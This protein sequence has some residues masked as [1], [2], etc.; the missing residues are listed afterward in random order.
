MLFLRLRLPES[1][2][3]QQCPQ[4]NSLVPSNRCKKSRNFGTINL[5]PLIRRSIPYRLPIMNKVLR[6]LSPLTKCIKTAKLNNT[7]VEFPPDSGRWYIVKCEEHTIRFGLRPLQGAAKHLNGRLHG[8]LD[9]SWALATEMLGYRVIDCTKELA[10]LNNEVVNNAF[11]HGYKPENEVKRK[12]HPEIPENASHRTGATTISRKRSGTSQTSIGCKSTSSPSRKRRKEDWSNPT[13]IITN[14]KT[15]HVYYCFWKDHHC[16]YPVMILAWDN[17][18]P[19]GLEHDLVSTGLLDKNSNPPN[20]YIYKDTD[21]GKNKAIAGWAPGF[22]DGGSKV[23]QRKFPAMFFDP[24]K[25]VSWVSANLLSKFP[26]FEPDPPKKRSHPFNV[27]RR[28]VAKN[29]GFA[30]WEEFEE[31]QKEKGREKRERWVSTP[32][33]SPLSEINDAENGSDTESSA[34][35]YTS[36]VTEKVLQEMRDRAGEITGDSDYAGSD[37][38]STLDDEH[39][40]WE[41]VETDGRPWAW[42]VLRKKSHTDLGKTESSISTPDNNP[43]N[44][45]VEFSVRE[46]TETARRLSIHACTQDEDYSVKEG[47]NAKASDPPRRTVENPAQDGDNQSSRGTPV[48]NLYTANAVN[49]ATPPLTG[50]I[51]RDIT[52]TDDHS[53]PKHSPPPPVAPVFKPKEPLGPAVFELSSYSKGSISWNRENEETSLRLY[54]G[55]GDRVVGTVDAPVNI[56]IDPTTLGGITREEIPESR[57]NVAMTLFGKDPSDASVK[58]VFD[59]PMGSKADIGKVQSRK[60]LRWIRSVVP[61]L[62]LLEG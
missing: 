5:Y 28:W 6:E 41:Q 44:N 50:P 22:E 61:T 9:R 23:Q 33:V 32:S 53:E 7:I 10:A 56:V 40:E 34:K 39:K 46:G 27:A 49:Q 8:G 60:F 36:N 52:K 21:S 13:D 29:K 25:G 47:P 31:A 30:S 51:L 18:E 37:A 11:A 1:M 57:G 54:Y 45:K 58:V 17:Q 14:P 16:L 2:M 42:Y 12:Q 20:C 59:R 19:G 35:S 24:D 15:F 26:L 55:E 4:S 38:D 62:P 43:V 3:N 48:T